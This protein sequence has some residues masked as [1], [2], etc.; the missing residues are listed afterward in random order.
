[1]TFRAGITRQ[2]ITQA[3]DQAACPWKP[4]ASLAFGDQCALTALP[5]GAT[6]GCEI[7]QGPD[8]I[9]NVMGLPGAF[10]DCP[11]P[12]RRTAP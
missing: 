6:F 5:S 1:M 4:D 9:L 7:L 8:P 12:T 2:Q 10:H 3:L 11:A